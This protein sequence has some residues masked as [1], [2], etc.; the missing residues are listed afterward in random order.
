MIFQ[1]DRLNRWSLLQAHKKPVRRRCPSSTSGAAFIVYAHVQFNDAGLFRRFTTKLAR[2]IEAFP[3]QPLP[4]PTNP[5]W[6]RF[7]I[8]IS[9][10]MDWPIYWLFYIFNALTTSYV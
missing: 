9:Q 3:V 7:A 6:H 8:F 10:I 2:K 1:S 4:L 5:G